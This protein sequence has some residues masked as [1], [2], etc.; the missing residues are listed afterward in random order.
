MKASVRRMFM[1]TVRA[2]ERAAP[3]EF[4]VRH[5][6]AELQAAVVAS[7]DGPVENWERAQ[8]LARHGLRIA[9]RFESATAEHGFKVLHD[10]IR[11]YLAGCGPKD[12]TGRATGAAQ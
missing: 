8:R 7:C 11:A 5:R 10:T 2:A 6:L 3:I 12:T 1:R 9:R 4:R